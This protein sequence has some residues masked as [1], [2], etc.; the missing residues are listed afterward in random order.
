MQWCTTAVMQRWMHKCNNRCMN[1]VMNAQMQWWMH[2]CSDECTNTVMN[3]WMQW[4]MHECSDECTNAVMNAW[5]QWWMH[6]CSDECTNP[7]MHECINWT[8]FFKY[9]LC[10]QLNIFQTRMLLTQNPRRLPNWKPSLRHLQRRNRTWDRHMPTCPG[11]PKQ[12]ND[13]LQYEDVPRKT[14]GIQTGASYSALT[15]ETA[16]IDQHG[17]CELR[18]EP[19][20]AVKPAKKCKPTPLTPKPGSE[21]KNKNASK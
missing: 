3:L 6:E 18:K 19:A 4:W 5:M 7:V 17:Y 15:A 14:N 21:Q 11:Y 20:K 9:F 1:A 2:E 13:E 16:I 8:S 10:F 12:V